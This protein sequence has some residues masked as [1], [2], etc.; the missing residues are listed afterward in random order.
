MAKDARRLQHLRVIA[1]ANHLEISATRKGSTS[2][3]D[4]LAWPGLRIR[5]IFEPNVSRPVKN[6]RLQPSLMSIAIFSVVTFG[7]RNRSMASLI[8]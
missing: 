1:A 3:Y 6:R 5:D 2:A 4:D 7:W 8:R